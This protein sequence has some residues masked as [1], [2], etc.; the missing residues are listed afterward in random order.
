MKI[1]KAKRNDAGALLGLTKGLISDHNPSFDCIL[2]AKDIIDTGFGSDPLFEAFVAE[3]EAGEIAGCVSFYRG[4]AGWHGKAIAVV[5]LLFV[6]PSARG[7][8]V[9]RRLMAA[10][11]SEIVARDWLRIELFVE[12]E[13]PAAAFYEAIGMQ[14]CHH[15]HYQI[16]GDALSRLAGEL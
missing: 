5:H 10:V 7:K 2:E 1:R 11:A 15:R 4:Y 3:N 13:R 6:D 9:A 8:G 14:N 12:E 16:R